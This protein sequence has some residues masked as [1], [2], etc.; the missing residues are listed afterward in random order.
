[1]LG[2]VR[3]TVATL[4]WLPHR[5]TPSGRVIGREK[6]VFPS[7]LL[8]SISPREME[9]GSVTSPSVSAVTVTVAGEISML[10]SAAVAPP[11]SMRSTVK[12]MDTTWRTGTVTS[13]VSVLTVTFCR[14]AGVPSS[15]M[16]TTLVVSVRVLLISFPPTEARA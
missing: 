4:G 9:S 16:R 11:P 13:T 1:M 8:R 2:K 15:P 5:V 10:T 12:G 14:S 7:T 6:D 3:E